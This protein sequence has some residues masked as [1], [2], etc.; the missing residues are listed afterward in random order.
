VFSFGV[1]AVDTFMYRGA[2]EN[3]SRHAGDVSP[4]S[5]V[6]TGLGADGATPQIMSLT[7]EKMTRQ[8]NMIT[9]VQLAEV[10]AVF[11]TILNVKIRPR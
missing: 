9:T 3:W 1:S 10:M 7:G 6:I 4:A 5:P 11:G 2:Q 8:M